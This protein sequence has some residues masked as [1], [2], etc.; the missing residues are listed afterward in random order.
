MDIRGAVEFV[1][2]ILAAIA[3]A[4]AIV[5]RTFLIFPSRSN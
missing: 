2:A 5:I 3:A 1:A 4:G